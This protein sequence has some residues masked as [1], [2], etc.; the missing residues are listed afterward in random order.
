[1]R[2]I[3]PKLDEIVNFVTNY[4][5]LFKNMPKNIVKRLSIFSG[6]V[7][8]CPKG[9]QRQRLFQYDIDG[10]AE[11]RYDSKY[12]LEAIKWQEKSSTA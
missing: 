4:F 6:M 7:D 5:G 3:V 12:N 11:Y 10:L 8:L 2:K 9:L 1:M